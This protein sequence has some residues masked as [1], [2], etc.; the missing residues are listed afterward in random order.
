MDFDQ[1]RQVIRP[2]YVLRTEKQGG[3]MVNAIVDKIP[4]VSQD[5]TW[6]WWKK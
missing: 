5:A 2:L 4:A 1:A 6:G 3:R